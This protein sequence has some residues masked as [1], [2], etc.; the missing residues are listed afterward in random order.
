[1]HAPLLCR[2]A[3]GS[4]EPVGTVR[5]LRNFRKFRNFRKLEVASQS[6]QRTEAQKGTEAEMNA[7]ERFR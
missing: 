1:M 6:A 5:N 7:Q 2:L 4:V 3:T